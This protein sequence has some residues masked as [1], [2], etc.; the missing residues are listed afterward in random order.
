M[1]ATGVTVV[2][3]APLLVS[4]SVEVD[5]PAGEL[6]ALLADPRRHHELDGSGTVQATVSGPDR[7][8][9]GAKFSVGMKQFGLPYRITS[10]VTGFED[11]TLLEWRH[12]AQHVWRWEFTALSAGTTRITETW[13]ARSAKAVPATMF[14]LLSYGR[15][16][17]TGIEATLTRLQQRYAH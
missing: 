12:P 8:S 15:K 16:N 9:A 10:E 14:K 13:D 6:F 1:A 11:G 7:L 4:R 5:A 17:A 2:E 3:S